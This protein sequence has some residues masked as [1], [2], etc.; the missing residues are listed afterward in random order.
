MK[1]KLKLFWARFMVIRFYLWQGYIL[2]LFDFIKLYL[3]WCKEYK[4][5]YYEMALKRFNELVDKEKIKNE[6]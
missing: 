1:Q 4:V 6:K 3:V 2:K 5:T